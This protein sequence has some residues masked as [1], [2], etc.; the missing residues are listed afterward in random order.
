MT[1]RSS[2]KYA[3]LMIDYNMPH[4]VDKI[5]K[6]IKEEEL[7]IEGDEY[8]LEKEPHVTLVPCL[9]NDVKVDDLKPLVNDL[10][11]Y[12]AMITDVSKFEC[13][14]YD[15]LKCNI[16]SMVMNDTNN[17]ITKKFETH[18]EFDYHPHMTIAY[19]KKGAAD[20]YLQKSLPNLTIIEPKSFIYS[21]HDENGENIIE[22][23]TK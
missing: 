2:N 20:K 21:Y 18:T 12:K 10:H 1:A 23:F 3:F 19:M 11:T 15:V 5:Q 4:I 22:T 17:R 16:S 8:G 14:D 9:D 6:Q 13:E 7:Y